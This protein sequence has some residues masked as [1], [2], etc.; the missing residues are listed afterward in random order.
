MRSAPGYTIKNLKTD[1]PDF[2]VEHGLS[3]DIEAR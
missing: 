3:P 1:V 2:A